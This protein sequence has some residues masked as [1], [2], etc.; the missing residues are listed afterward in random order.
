MSRQVAS[1]RRMRTKTLFDYLIGYLIFIVN[2]IRNFVF[3]LAKAHIYGFGK[4]GNRNLLCRLLYYISVASSHVMAAGHT[5]SANRELTSPPD[6]FN[7]A[8]YTSFAKIYNASYCCDERNCFCH[9]PIPHSRER[10]LNRSSI[11][12]RY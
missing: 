9:A 11:I 5:L 10:N 12:C 1:I 8:E 6:I 3:G 2:N 7:S 4:V